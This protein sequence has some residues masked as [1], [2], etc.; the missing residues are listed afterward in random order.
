MVFYIPHMQYKRLNSCNILWSNWAWE[1]DICKSI[2]SYIYLLEDEYIPTISWTS[3]C[4]PI[5][6]MSNIKVKYITT[7]K[8]IEGA[9]WIKQLLQDIEQI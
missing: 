9:I 8:S 2:I 3:K 6:A 7:I 4:E 1:I 5:V